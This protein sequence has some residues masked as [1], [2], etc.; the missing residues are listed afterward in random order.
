MAMR[1]LFLHHDI[2]LMIHFGEW[3]TLSNTLIIHGGIMAYDIR[4]IHLNSKVIS[5]KING[6]EY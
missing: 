2:F 1:G 6:R 5:Y 4:F 3:A